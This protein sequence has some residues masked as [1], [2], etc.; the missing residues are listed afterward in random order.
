MRGKRGGDPSAKPFKP[1]HYINKE[2]TEDGKIL[3]P[4]HPKALAY[5][6]TGDGKMALLGVMYIASRGEVSPVG[7]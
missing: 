4:G 2:Y 6:N 5:T 1:V 7:G 3:D